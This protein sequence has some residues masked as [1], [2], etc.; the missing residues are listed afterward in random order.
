MAEH[1]G[2]GYGIFWCK[3][4]QFAFK[5]DLAQCLNLARVGDAV[6]SEYDV[7]LALVE[8]IRSH[9]MIRL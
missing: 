1:L 4:C 3:P 2:E 9:N 7:P 8:M 6:N 5:N